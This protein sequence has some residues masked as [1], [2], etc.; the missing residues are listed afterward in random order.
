[1]I[2]C[3]SIKTIVIENY[4]ILPFDAAK[5]TNEQYIKA[6]NKQLQLIAENRAYIIEQI[7]SAD[8]Y[9]IKVIFID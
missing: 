5:M 2:S 7:K 1:M 6:L 4:R 3:Q 8:G 9:I